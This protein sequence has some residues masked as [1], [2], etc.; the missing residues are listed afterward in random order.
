MD[1][2]SDRTEYDRDTPRPWESLS[3]LGLPNGFGDN[4]LLLRGY[5]FSSNIYFFTGPELA[6]VD[7]GND[8]T[9]FMELARLGY[10]LPGIRRIVLTHGHHDHAMGFF[11][12]VRSYP[13]HAG[14]FQLLMHEAGPR[15][16]REF[17]TQVGCTVTL[18]KN[19]DAVELGGSVWNVVHTPGHTVDSICLHHPASKTAFTGDTVLPQVMAA[20][21]KSAGGRLD[22]YLFSLRTLRQCDIDNVLPGHG[23]P[24]AALGK[25]VIEETY[26][27][28]MM[29]IIGVE[30]TTSWI[31]GAIQLAQKGFLEEA[32]F[33][34]DKETAVHPSHIQA[35]QTKAACLNDLGRFEEALQTIQ[36]INTPPELGRQYVF[37]PV[38]KGYALMGLGNYE[39]S[40]KLFDQ[41]LQLQPESRDARM[42]K[43]IALYLA[44]RHDEAFEIE[45]FRTE[46][47]GRFKEQLSAM[48]SAKPRPPQS[49][50]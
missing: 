12:L 16:Y 31:N 25:R 40:V 11:E 21:D 5:D 24:V 41:A 3:T 13:R 20:A 32:I 45:I 7:P 48:S 14:S 19:G 50:M 37:V 8:Y 6:L 1:Q 10:K 22:Y 28:L 47:E 34:C 33:C 15:E 23:V 44:G 4:I 46:F 2:Q 26:E 17:A 9:A 39:E 42:Y 35:L 38:A 29:K 43:G 18:L 30:K 36:Q 49:G 27:S